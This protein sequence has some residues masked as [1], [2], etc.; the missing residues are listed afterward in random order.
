M[1]RQLEN[2]RQINKKQAFEIKIKDDTGIDHG[3]MGSRVTERM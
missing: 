3:E 1:V 2:Q